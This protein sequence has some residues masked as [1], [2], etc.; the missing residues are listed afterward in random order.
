MA[1]AIFAAGCFWGV[2][3]TF[4]NTEGVMDT[5]V[6]YI[7]GFTDAP[8]Y[9]TVCSGQTGHAEAVRVV[10][11]PGKVSYGELLDV[12]WQ[13]HDPRQLNRQGPDTGTQY[14]TAIFCMDDEQ[15]KVAEASKAE[16]QNSARLQ[17]VIVTEITAAT[18]FFMAEEYH[19]QY[20]EKRG[21]SL[22]GFVGR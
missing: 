19:Q 4:R 15:R 3:H 6:G 8:S 14:R 21:P 5:A 16:L 2:E 17:G 7:G 22:G 13:C 10:F 1:D 18:E 20:F 9:E 11:D 12:F